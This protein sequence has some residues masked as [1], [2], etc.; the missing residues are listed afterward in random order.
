MND[1]LK[2]ILAYQLVRCSQF[3]GYSSRMGSRTHIAYINLC[4]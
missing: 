3:K 2:V 1:D 4:L